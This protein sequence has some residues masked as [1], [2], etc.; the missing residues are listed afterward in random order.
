M[1]DFFMPANCILAGTAQKIRQQE[2]RCRG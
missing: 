2:D 1:A